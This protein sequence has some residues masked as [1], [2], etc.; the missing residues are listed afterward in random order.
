MICIL[1]RNPFTLDIETWILATDCHDA[2]RQAEAAG[3]LQLASVLYRQEWLRPGK[4]DLALSGA[5]YTL[6]S[7]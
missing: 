6:L 4:H 7:T 1:K 3:E 2:R 5:H